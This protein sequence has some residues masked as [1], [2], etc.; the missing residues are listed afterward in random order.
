MQLTHAEVSVLAERITV[1]NRG[2]SSLCKQC[3]FMGPQ[4][5]PQL[6][7]LQAARVLLSWLPLTLARKTLVDKHIV[8]TKYPPACSSAGL[9]DLQTRTHTT[10]FTNNLDSAGADHRGFGTSNC[11]WPLT[12]LVQQ[13]HCY[14][15]IGRIW[16]LLVFNHECA[17]P[18]NSLMCQ[19]KP[20]PNWTNFQTHR[21]AQQ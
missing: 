10:L 12:G 7:C 19:H 1:V 9:Q 14:L 17:S 16:R 5:S 21:A 15:N 2:L 18:H 13:C 3:M 11:C 8:L 20:H 6:K 4:V